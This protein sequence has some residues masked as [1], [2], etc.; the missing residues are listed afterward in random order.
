MWNNFTHSIETSGLTVSNRQW[1]SSFWL[2]ASHRPPWAPCSSPATFLPFPRAANSGSC[3]PLVQTDGTTT[4]TSL[5]SATPT[6]FSGNT[7][8][9]RRTLLFSCGLDFLKLYSLYSLHYTTYIFLW[10]EWKSISSNV[11]FFQ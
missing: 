6:R 4:V 1:R 11:M 10:S 7:E 5:M 8:S 2:S 9:Q 3:W